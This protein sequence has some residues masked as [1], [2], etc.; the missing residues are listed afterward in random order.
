MARAPAGSR[1]PN[2]EGPRIRFQIVPEQRSIKNRMHLDVNA[3]GGRGVPLDIRR[4][5]DEA[6]AARLVR[7]G[8]TRLRTILDERMDHHAVALTDPEDNKF[9]INQPL[10]CDSRRWSH[11]P[12]WQGQTRVR[13]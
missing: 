8:A 9:D 13:E 4:E 7:L 11:H 10:S 6:E 5:G 3:G 12:K 2:G 1:N